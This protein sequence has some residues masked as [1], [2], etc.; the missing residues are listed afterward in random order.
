M[1]LG[2]IFPTCEIGSDP[3]LIRDWAQTA[4][5]LGY[6]HIVFYDHVL[7]AQHADRTPALPGPYTENDPFHEPFVVMSFIA[8]VT[9]RIELATGILILPQRQ[10]ALVAKQ[11]AEL[12]VLS[13]G[14]LRLGVGTG[15]NRVEYESLGIDYATRGNRFTEQVELLRQLWRTPVVDFDGDF[16]RVER[17]GILPRPRPELPIWFGGFNEVAFRRAARLG[18]GFHYGS[19]PSRM[20]GMLERVQQMLCDNGRDPAGFG[21]EALVDFSASPDDWGPEIEIWE[22]KGGSHLSVRAMDT[23]AEFAGER[24]VGY[25]GPTSFIDALEKFMKTVR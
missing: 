6:S 15:W 11:A 25:E 12:D 23:A 2:A 3:E 1:N 13:K 17:A 7:G 5:G 9:T 22:K 18:D 19:R 10:T 21:G 16:H 8:A 24:V 14:R 4:E 20:T